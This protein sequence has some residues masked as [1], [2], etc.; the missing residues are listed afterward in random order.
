MGSK[1]MTK[2]VCDATAVFRSKRL[3]LGILAVIASQ[4]GSVIPAL[5]QGADATACGAAQGYPVARPLKRQE[6]MVGNYSHADQLNPTHL[7]AAADQPSTLRRA[8]QELSLTYT[9]Q[10]QSHTLQDY[11]NRNPTTN[12]NDQTP[13]QPGL[14]TPLFAAHLSESPPIHEFRDPYQS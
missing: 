9:F 14:L 5:A 1:V 8:K 12:D 4:F 10:G 11:L 2:A 3:S 6:N 7:V 13:P